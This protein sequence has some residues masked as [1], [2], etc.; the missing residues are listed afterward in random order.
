MRKIQ[1]VHLREQIYMV[2]I[3]D[4]YHDMVYLGERYD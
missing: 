4:E 2:Y 1:L 3:N